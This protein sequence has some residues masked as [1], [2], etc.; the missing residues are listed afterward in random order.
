MFVGKIR[1]LDGVGFHPLSDFCPKWFT[2]CG[3]IYLSV[4]AAVVS[5]NRH[6]G[7]DCFVQ[8]GFSVS[9]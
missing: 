4:S 9:N 2:F 5:N 8:L 3:R 1:T 7:V 6:L